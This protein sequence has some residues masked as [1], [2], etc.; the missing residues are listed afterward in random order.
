[1]FH[2][3]FSTPRRFLCEWRPPPRKVLLLLP[4]VEILEEDTLRSSSYFVF[5]LLLLIQS[6]INSSRHNFL[7]S[8]YRR[9]I[10]SLRTCF[11]LKSFLRLDV[12]W[13]LV[14]H[15]RTM[16]S[17]TG[18]YKSFSVISTI[19][20][21]VFIALSSDNQICDIYRFFFSWGNSQS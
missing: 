5:D 7:F 6:S 17:L 18:T 2:D 19:I 11:A 9:S 21:V 20:F 10:L 4:P 8:C 12:Q 16:V 15:K 3:R 14:S 13:S 1:M